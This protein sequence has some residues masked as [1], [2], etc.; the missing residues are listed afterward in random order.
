MVL[1]QQILDSRQ[2]MF[3]LN[4]RICDIRKLAAALGEVVVVVADC[5]QISVVSWLMFPD[6]GYGSH[7]QHS[8]L[9]PSSSACAQT[10]L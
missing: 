3:S 9:H 8:L 10:G 2:H 1:A 6:D 4:V 5:C 7:T